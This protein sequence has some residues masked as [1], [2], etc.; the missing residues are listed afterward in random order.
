MT[1][2]PDSHDKE[3]ERLSVPGEASEADIAEGEQAWDVDEG[4]PRPVI[5]PDAT[6]ADVLDQTRPAHL[7]DDDRAG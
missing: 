2:T 3:V 6:E 7:E 5:P 4:E 1:S